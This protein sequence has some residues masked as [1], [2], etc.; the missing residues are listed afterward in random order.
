MRNAVTASK[1]ANCLDFTDNNTIIPIFH[2]RKHKSPLNETANEELDSIGR[3]GQL[4]SPEREEIIMFGHLDQ[5]SHSEFLSNVLFY[6]GGFI[7]SKLVKQLT[8]KA[9]RDSLVSDICPS[10]K[11]DHDY[12][13]VS[14][15]SE[16]ATAS[17]FTLFVNN[18]GLPSLFS[19]PSSTASMF[20]KHTSARKKAKPSV[21]RSV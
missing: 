17:A 20:L 7:V 14:R 2:T 15:Y 1:N 21:T 13:G 18:G 19:T 12:C 4:I 10:K 3:Q 9:C 5:R 8:C 11:S 6:I 16:V